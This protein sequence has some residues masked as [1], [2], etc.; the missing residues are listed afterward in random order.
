MAYTFKGN[1]AHADAWYIEPEPANENPQRCELCAQ[2]LHRESSRGECFGIVRELA[3]KRYRTMT[4]SQDGAR[5][6]Q[7]KRRAEP[8]EDTT[9]L[10]VRNHRHRVADLRRPGRKEKETP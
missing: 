1:R 10:A 3:G 7:F 6:E 4:L 2:W 9:G 5:C 8:A